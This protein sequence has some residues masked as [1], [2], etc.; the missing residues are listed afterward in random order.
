[1]AIRVGSKVRLIKDYECAYMK[2][3]LEGVLV[4]DI[5]GR[6]TVLVCFPG[7]DGHSGNGWIKKSNENAKLAQLIGSDGQDF[8]FV[9]L[10]N[11]KQ[12]NPIKAIL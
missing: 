10:K 1:M 7:K 3:M 11:L 5:P 12:I 9:P 4:E 8:Y 6:P 2:G